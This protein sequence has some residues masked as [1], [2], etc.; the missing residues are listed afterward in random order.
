MGVRFDWEIE[1]E[2]TQVR[3]AGESVESIRKRRVARLRFLIFLLVILG[4][5]GGI[6]AFVVWRLNSVEQEIEQA[7]R[8][9]VDAEFT[10][11]RLGDYASY[12]AIQRSASADWLQVQQ[13]IFN[14]YQD[15][16]MQEGVQLSGTISDITIERT[17]AR[18]SVQEIV[19]GVPYTRV[20]FYWR[21]EDGWHHVPPDYT[22]WGELEVHKVQNVTV[23]YNM[24]DKVFGQAVAEK[25]A[26][27]IQAACTALICPN[28]PEL[29]IEVV[30]DEALQAAWAAGDDWRL[31]V[32]SPYVRRA[33][34]D[35]PFD[36]DYQ[37][38]VAEKLADRLVLNSS[39]NLQ[40]V[41][42]TDAYY[43][44]QAIVSWLVGSMVQVDTRSYVVSSL[45]T[46]Y[47]S[48]A[49]GQLLNTLRPDSN[50]GVLAQVTGKSLEQTG[51]DWRDYLTWRLALEDELLQKRD[52]ANYLALYD[53]RDEAARNLAYQR[54]NMNTPTGEKLVTSAQP[55]VLTDGTIN[56]KAVV[57]T[58]DG[59]NT[60]QSEAIFRLADGV[61]KRVN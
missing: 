12:S 30:P 36:V 31:Q 54:F 18:V 52:E 16:K 49:V 29:T 35:M 40:P 61:W 10:S 39:S 33:R 19:N 32:P 44:R 7:L 47:G 9:T 24:V 23:R 43:L 42:P 22:F 21:Y 56:L 58:S 51:L 6:G 48:A 37:L 13:Q 46:N 45:M 55:E 26:G 5:L 50:I 1:A 11:L 25:V 59:A 8:G 14:Q 28:M 34:S 57:V 15:L 4:I 60:Q 17:R 27:W 20:W 53:T 38:S 41:Y 2:K 3:R